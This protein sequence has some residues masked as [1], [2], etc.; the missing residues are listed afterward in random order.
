MP[1]GGFGGHI[2]GDG[3]RCFAAGSST[4]FN[5]IADRDYQIDTIT[6]D[7]IEIITGEKYTFNDIDK[8]HELQVSFIP[9]QAAYTVPTTTEYGLIFLAALLTYFKKRL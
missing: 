4:T 9:R 2:S 5:F 3:Q 7:G 6:V 8:N 1:T